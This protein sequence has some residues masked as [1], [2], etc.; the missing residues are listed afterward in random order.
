MATDN[1]QQLFDFHWLWQRGVFYTDVQE[2]KDLTY[3]FG[4]LKNEIF[5]VVLPKLNRPQELDLQAIQQVFTKMGEIP[6]FY[7]AED[8]KKKGFVEYLIR[9]GYSL[10]GTD[11]WM[12]LEPSLYKKQEPKSEV[13]TITADNFKDF[14]TVLSP[15]FKDFSGNET[16]LE[17]CKQ[18]IS[19][20]IG[21]EFAKDLK[22]ELYLI[23]DNGKPA[24]GAGIFY[25]VEK[26][27]A[28]LHDAG[29]LE[30]FRGR[31]Y[32]TDLIEF[33]TNRAIDLGIDRVYTLVEHGGQSWKN[34]IKN[35]FN[36]AH[37]ADIVSLKKT[38]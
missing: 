28:Y 14:Y 33:R 5:D 11:T 19:K 20:N 9:A 22:L 29:T 12:V 8:L 34:M 13:I 31:G 24:S 18:C 3:Y 30:E 7:L 16:Y 36:Q 35:G 27:F 37:M 15:V 6:S 21:N 23:Y 32:Q 17:I 26:N 2:G 4:P 10:T 1:F 38:A 25:S